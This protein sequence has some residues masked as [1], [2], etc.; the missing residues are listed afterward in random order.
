MWFHEYVA[1]ASVPDCPADILAWSPVAWA[2]MSDRAGR[3]LSVVQI[4]DAHLATHS[5]F[6]W[7]TELRRLQVRAEDAETEL[8]QA[9]SALKAAKSFADATDALTTLRMPTRVEFEDVK[10]AFASLLNP[11]PEEFAS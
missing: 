10:T 2:F 6:E 7:M 3:L 5:P 8:D 11:Q 4:V 1:S 9:L